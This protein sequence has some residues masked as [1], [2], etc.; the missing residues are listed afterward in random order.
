MMEFGE[1]LGQW[2]I[3]GHDEQR[4]VAKTSVRECVCN[5]DH[6]PT[7]DVLPG[8]DCANSQFVGQS[9]PL[10]PAKSIE[11]SIL[12]RLSFVDPCCIS[13]KVTRTFVVCGVKWNKGMV[14]LDVIR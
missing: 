1:R 10:Y 12:R 4:T 6:A 2:M 5:F 3:V 8:L 11:V 13:S 7:N 9:E 14:V